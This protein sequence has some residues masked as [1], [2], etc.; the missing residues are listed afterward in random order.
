MKNA[1]TNAP[2]IL[3]TFADAAPSDTTDDVGVRC[4]ACGLDD[5]DVEEAIEDGGHIPCGCCER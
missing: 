3:Y 5:F 1:P 2:T 4:A